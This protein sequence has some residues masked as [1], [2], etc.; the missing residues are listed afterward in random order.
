MSKKIQTAERVSQSDVSDNYV[1]QRSLL[2]YVEA[3]NI[4]HGNVLEIGTGSGYGVEMLSEKAKTFLTIDKFASQVG[5]ELSEKIDNVEFRQM[6]VPPLTGLPDNHFDFVVSFQV[7]EHIKKDTEYV[8]EIHRVLKEGGKFIVTT[9][10]KKMSLTRNPWHIREYTV[11]ELTTLLGNSFSKVESKGVFGN[12]VVM[13]Y[14][15]KNKASVRRIMRFDIL[16]LQY[17]L[18]RQILQIPYDIM[19]R[20]NR[21]K[22]SDSGSHI[23]MEDYFISEAKDDCIDLFYIAEK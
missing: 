11:A 19:N 21:N 12:D 7:I 22:L 3:A 8:K 10:N 15:N 6:N 17:N 16:N 4:I 9:P 20:R 18:P 2:A 1:F 13:E 14:Y 23:K 5:T